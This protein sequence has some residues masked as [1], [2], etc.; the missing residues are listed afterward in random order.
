M[1][2][3]WARRP[4][5]RGRERLTLW[6]YGHHWVVG[7]KGCENVWSC[8][9]VGSKRVET[10]R[11]PVVMS[12]RNGAWGLAGV[13][14]HCLPRADLIDWWVRSSDPDPCVHRGTDKSGFE[15]YVI[16]GYLTSGLQSVSILV[17]CICPMVAGKA[18]TGDFH[19]TL[20][21]FQICFIYFTF[22][23]VG[24]PDRGPIQ[25]MTMSLTLSE[26]HWGSF[27][28]TTTTTRRITRD[29]SENFPAA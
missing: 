1:H 12:V 23:T 15:D 3:R 6:R 13:F 21:D 22:C 4:N 19:L 2:V 17:I 27:R 24:L 8:E 28:E 29:G 10:G 5:P 9:Q 18:N 7:L 16:H 26:V 11:G 20:C 14:D 25:I